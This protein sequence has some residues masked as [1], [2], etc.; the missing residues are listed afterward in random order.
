MFSLIKTFLSVEKL[1]IYKPIRQ[2]FFVL[3]IKPGIDD[4]ALGDYKKSSNYVL[5]QRGIIDKEIF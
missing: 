1:L 5:I 4:E 2:S 3:S